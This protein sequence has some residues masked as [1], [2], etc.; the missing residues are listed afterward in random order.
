TFFVFS[1]TSARAGVA[2]VAVANTRSAD[3]VRA[4]IDPLIMVYLLL[5][6]IDAFF[7]FGGVSIAHIIPHAARGHPER[8]AV[9]GKRK[10]TPGFR[11]W[12]LTFSLR[13]HFQPPVA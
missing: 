5:A 10:R 11:V 4:E 12:H 2:S 1:R 8:E 7:T 13:R 6:A 9:N 3:S